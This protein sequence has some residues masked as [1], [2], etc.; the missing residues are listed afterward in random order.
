MERTTKQTKVLQEQ[1]G[2]RVIYLG[3]RMLTL[4]ETRR[5]AALELREIRRSLNQAQNAKSRH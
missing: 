1:G 4:H 2:Y 5:N 3:K